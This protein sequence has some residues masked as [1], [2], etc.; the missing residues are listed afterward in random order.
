MAEVTLTLRDTP[1]GVVTV[2]STYVPAVGART[3]RAQSIG[4]DLHNRAAHFADVV[5]LAPE[6]GVADA[7]GAPA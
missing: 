3:T 5:A 7:T 1:E 4:M 6:P 2:R